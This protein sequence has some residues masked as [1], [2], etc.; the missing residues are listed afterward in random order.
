MDAPTPLPKVERFFQLSLLGML[1]CGFFAVS[2]SGLLGIAI[3][4]ITLAAFAVRAAKVL[5]WISFEIGTRTVSILTLGCI[6]FYPLDYLYLTGVLPVATLHLM[7]LLAVLKL[8]TAS[9]ERDYV[10][11]KTIAG[12]E[13]LVAAVLPASFGFFAY[14]ALFLLFTIATFASGEV[15]RAANL[16]SMPVRAGVRPFGRRLGLFS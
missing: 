9:S 11:L 7:F 5:G 4:A 16:S 14:L 6:L 8:I 15:R 2:S 12:L 10:Y 13:L 1:A 3:Q